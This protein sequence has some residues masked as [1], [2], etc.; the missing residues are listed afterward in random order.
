MGTYVKMN[1][2]SGLHGTMESWIKV[3]TVNGTTV[4][5]WDTDEA[6]WDAINAGGGVAVTLSSEQ[7]ERKTA[8][9]IAAGGISWL[10]NMATQFGY[11]PDPNAS[12]NPPAAVTAG[13][14]VVE[15]HEAVLQVLEDERRK[16][17][18]L[19][20]A[21]GIGIVLVLGL[22]FAFKAKK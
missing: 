18:T 2:L 10:T 7:K 5:G 8:A 22:G 11:M 1:E 6:T 13:T 3:K 12:Q 17:S 4:E 15:Q 14:G 9:E 20:L 21:G 16:R 19:V